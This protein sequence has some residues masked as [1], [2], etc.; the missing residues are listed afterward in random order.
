MYER[1]Q[2]NESL[3]AREEQG[4]LTLIA[5]YIDKK[6]IDK[7]N[8][9]IFIKNSIPK[10]LTQILI[11]NYTTILYSNFDFKIIFYFIVIT[12]LFIFSHICMF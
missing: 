5:R 1:R 12:F 9:R 2:H 4:I 3:M 10:N 7:E 6:K 8:F 11:V